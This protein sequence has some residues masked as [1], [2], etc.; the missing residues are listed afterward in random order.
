[1]GGEDFK[2][3]AGRCRVRPANGAYLGYQEFQ[4]LAIIGELLT[5]RHNLIGAIPNEACAAM[6]LVRLR[7]FMRATSAG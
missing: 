1:M 6:R 4:G 2:L 5:G 3:K 7:H